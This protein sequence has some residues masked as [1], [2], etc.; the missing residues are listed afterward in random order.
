MKRIL[1]ISFV[2]MAALISEAFAQRTVSGKVTSATDGEGIPGVNVLIKG[3]TRGVITDF[4]GN[5]RLEVPSEDAV[6]AFSAIGFLKQEI[7]V[8]NRSVIEVSLEEDVKQLEEVVVTGYGTSVKREITGSIASVSGESIENMPVASLDRAMQGRVAGVQ[9]NAASGQPGGA[10][11]VRVRGIGSF[12][13]NDPLYIVDGVQMSTN[14]TSGQASSNPLASINPND[15]ASIE[16]LKDAAASAIYGAQS[17]NGVVIVTTKKG[18]AGKTK[19]T[20][21]AQEGVVRPMNLY[22]M[23]NAQQFATIKR[24][25]YINNTGLGATEADRIAASDALFGDPN[26]PNLTDSNWQDALYRDARQRSYTLNARGGDEKTTFFISGAYDLQ[27]G[28]IIMS[29]YTRGSLRANLSHKATDKFTLNANL[30]LAVQEYNGSIANGN[31]VNSPFVAG[32][33]AWPTAPI[34][35]ED[36][37]FA[38]YPSSHLFGYNIVQ[39]VNEE[40]RNGVVASTV[41]NISA[42]YQII[43]SLSFTSFAG[44]NFDDGRDMNNRPSSIPIFAG[45]GGQTAVTD[46]RNIN[47]NT[48][49]NLNFYKKFNDVHTVSSILGVEYKKESQD[50]FS[51]TGRGFAYPELYTLQNSSTPQAVTGFFT[52]YVRA[53]AFFNGKYDF[54]DRYA[55]DLTFRRDGSS[56]FGSDNRWGNFYAVAGSWR[57]SSESFMDGVDFLNDLKLRA[58]YG[59]L[60]NSNGISNFASRG[61][62]GS[63]GQYATIAAVRPTQL[64]NNLL[65]WERSTQINLGLDYAFFQNRVSG[66]VD[67]WRTDTEDQLLQL[68]LP[69]D[70]GFDFLTQNVGNIRNEGID[71][72]LSTVN[73]DAGGFQWTT[74]FNISFLDNVVTELNG[75]EEQTQLA[76]G[77]IVRVGEPLGLFFGVPY[78]GVNPANGRAMFYDSLGNIT[79]RPIERDRV[80]LGNSVS[81]YYGGLNNTFKYKG[82]SLDVFFQY[83]FGADAYN[84]DL[85]NLAGSGSVTDNQLVSEL[86]YWKQPGDITNVPRPYEGAF[87]RGIEQGFPNFESGRYISDASYIRLKQVTLGYDLPS[88]ALSRIGLDRVRVFVQGLNL[89]TWT[90][91]EGIDPEVIN[92]NLGGGQFGSFGNYPNGRVYT[93]G[94]TIGL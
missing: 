68:A 88:N 7:P 36:G 48:N 19:F 53:G 90:E 21:T 43:P 33:S 3:T 39:G 50:L 60:G 63:A 16:I 40:L 45:F 35:N 85:L 42:T 13:N 44:I 80:I 28:Q 22:D 41:S 31:F 18:K 9:V 46:R 10:M 47:F 34:Y 15:I 54:D 5:Y 38:P 92:Q 56:R 79:Y 27:E 17:A 70:S 61:L 73:V 26:D 71:V 89:V 25:A 24:Q 32:F 23:M 76:N 82:L 94:L 4:E 65:G 37:T 59:V 55:I 87:D 51:A 52:E 84:W 93:A 72:A 8:G 6:L 75:D 81:D 67:V 14:S 91:F 49:H 78:A 20:A 12:A 66:S 86:N 30:S 77:Q 58:S 64:E 74:T 62:F 57:I 11:N 83:D 29:D 69:G 2:L 1:L